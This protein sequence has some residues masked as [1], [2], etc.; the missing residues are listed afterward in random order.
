MPK[1]AGLPLIS[2]AK[3][4]EALYL[5]P[6]Q[7]SIILDCS[8]SK[9]TELIHALPHYIIGKSGLRVRKEVFYQHLADQ[10]A[11]SR[12]P[13]YPHLRLTQTNSRKM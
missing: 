7:I 8:I 3:E 6:K 9:A 5:T 13:T 10:E 2:P 4:G 11:A 12:E 1:K